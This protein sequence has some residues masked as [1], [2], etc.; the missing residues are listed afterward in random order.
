MDIG[1]HAALEMRETADLVNEPSQPPANRRGRAMSE[2]RFLTRAE[3][4]AHLGVGVTTFDAE[5][6]D[7]VWPPAMRRGT[8]TSAL[9][10]DRRLLPPI[11]W[12]G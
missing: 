4:A 10:W 6:R 7:G 2:P 11:A 12:A 3:A 5:V 8:K 9:T 1:Q